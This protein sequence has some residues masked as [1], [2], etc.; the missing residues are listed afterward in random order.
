MRIDG[1]E[2]RPLTAENVK[3]PE[4][5]IKAVSP[6]GRFVVAE[7]RTRG[8]SVFSIDAAGLSPPM[9]IVGLPPEFMPMGWT[10][11]SRSLFIESDSEK[12]PQVFRLD[13][14]TGKKEFVREIKQPDT[15]GIAVSNILLTPDGRGWV[16]SCLRRLSEIYL[17]E[18]LQ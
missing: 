7:N 15:T 14:R 18:G 3:L 4:L 8:W 1:T 17:V 10:E 6:D 2:I 12:A 13:W 9:E 5:M 11:D 16:Y